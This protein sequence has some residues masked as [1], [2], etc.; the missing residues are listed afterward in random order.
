MNRG[1]AESALALFCLSI[2]VAESATWAVTKW[3]WIVLALGWLVTA[4]VRFFGEGR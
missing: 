2:L 4:G 1:R 3:I